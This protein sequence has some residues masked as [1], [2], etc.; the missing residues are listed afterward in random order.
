ME[1]TRPIYEVLKE[2]KEEQAKRKITSD[3]SHK[4]GPE[5]TESSAVF[6][7]LPFGSPVLVFWTIGRGCE[8]P[9]K[10]MNFNYETVLSN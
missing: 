7:S 5:T 8:G 3:L 4:Y 10:F 9:F 1:R 6:R 2:A